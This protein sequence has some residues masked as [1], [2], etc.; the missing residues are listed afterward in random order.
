MF[1]LALNHYALIA[2]VVY[3]L[4]QSLNYFGVGIPAPVLGIV[5]VF[6]VVL[7]FVGS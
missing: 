5:G 2:L 7:A 6:F 3:V 4:L 1:S